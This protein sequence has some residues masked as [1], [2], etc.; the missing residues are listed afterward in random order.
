MRMPKFLQLSQ[1]TECWKSSLK[2]EIRAI[3]KALSS[4]EAKKV[5]FCHKR[6]K[7]DQSPWF[8]PLNETTSI[9]DFFIWESPSWANTMRLIWNFF[10][11]KILCHWSKT[12]FNKNVIILYGQITPGPGSFSIWASPLLRRLPLPATIQRF[13]KQKYHNAAMNIEIRSVTNTPRKKPPVPD[14]VGSLAAG[15]WATWQRGN[16]VFPHAWHQDSMSRTA[17]E[18]TSSINWS[19]GHGSS[20]PGMLYFVN[21]SW[22]CKKEILIWIT[23]HYVVQLPGIF[24]MGDPK[25][26]TPGPWTP[27]RTRSMDYL[28]DQS[29]DPFYGPPPYGP[30]QKIGEMWR[31]VK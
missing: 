29:T 16:S 26:L 23:C 14:T 11:I 12:F 22:E 15:H 6:L 1:K 31:S 13:L 5:T 4:N 25:T 8:G 17:S 7:W 24:K 10:P 21:G 28:T 19:R 2:P 18:F 9:L 30:P 20:Q 27:L 3:F